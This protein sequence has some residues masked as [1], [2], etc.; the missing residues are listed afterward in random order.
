MRV[1]YFIAVVLIGSFTASNSQAA[2]YE[3]TWKGSGGYWLEGAFSIP[4]RLADADF[5]DERNVQCFKINGYHGETAI[6]QWSLGDLTPET[7]WS[8]NFEPA[9]LQFR[10]GG[11]SYGPYGQEWNMD[12]TG[13]S[14]GK[15][16]FGF[17]AGGGWQDVCVNRKLIRASQIAPQTILKATRNND[18]RFK[19]GDCIFVSVS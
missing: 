1:I 11:L 13:T 18:I 4:D 10:T 6:G 3:F 17:N 15:N 8:L 12:G 7:F 2:S 9:K 5:I 19:S 14:C 16:G